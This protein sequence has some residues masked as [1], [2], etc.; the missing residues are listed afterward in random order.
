M[1]HIPERLKRMDRRSL[2]W[3]VVAAGGLFVL[4]LWWRSP[5]QPEAGGETTEQT[6]VVQPRPFTASISF[7]GTIKAGEGT[8]IVAP[9]DG[10]V[11]EMGFAYG[12]LVAPGQMLAVLDVS[13]L[14]QSRNEAE[15]AYLKAMQAARDMEGWASGPEVSR[16]RRAVESAR[17]D[18]ADTERKLAETKTLLDRGLVARTEYD[19]L[20]QQQRTQ[21]MAVT[22][23]N[24]D[25]RATMERG[26]GPN[27]RMAMLE[28]ENARARLT[29]VNAQFA[30]AVIRAK[31]A[32]II[33]R[34]PA[35]R[36]VA[37]VDSDTHVG[38]RVSRGQLIGIIAQAG[39][40]AVTFNI[41]EAD[42]AALKLNQPLMVSGPGFP[43][44][45]LPGKISAI[46][47]EASNPGG[48][49]TPGKASFTATASLDPLTPDQAAQ[50]R[51]GMT[52]TIAITTYTA[53][54]AL[55]IPPQAIRGSAPDASVLVRDERTGKD[56]P[57]KVQIGQVGPDGVEIVAGLKPGRTVVWSVAPPPLP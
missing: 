2:G 10:T 27:R 7:A 4:A 54:A 15:S 18:L 41:D 40:L 30:G 36:A 16:A 34:P 22:S 57:V 52:A 55:V 26:G 14:E 25:L 53:S 1:A 33:V 46:A 47:G 19:G 48:V 35:G 12:N 37:T 39:G 8:G 44:L 29:A 6:M 50:V 45:S 28:L 32:G 11:K 23:A 17:F 51:I 13:E 56:N 5:G 21:R 3:L 38:A 31:D 20:L 9:F 43:G 49:A 42:V 24:E